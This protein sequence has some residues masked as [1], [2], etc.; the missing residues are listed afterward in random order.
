MGLAAA[1]VIGGLVAGIVA[2]VVLGVGRAVGVEAGIAASRG[3]DFALIVEFLGEG[4]ATWIAMDAGAT[5]G[6]LLA[7]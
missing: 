3:L 4:R 1:F 6:E 7:A 2:R 5:P